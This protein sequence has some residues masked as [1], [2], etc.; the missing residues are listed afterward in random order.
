MVTPVDTGA[1]G[2]STIGGRTNA[3]PLPPEGRVC[4]ILQAFGLS[5]EVSWFYPPLAAAV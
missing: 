2:E 3:F 5:Q 1:R 4:A